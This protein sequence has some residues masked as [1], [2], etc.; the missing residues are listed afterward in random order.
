MQTTV[1]QKN[2]TRRIVGRVAVA[3]ALVVVPLAAVA[4]PALADTPSVV[5]VDRDNHNPGDRDNHNPGPGQP[6]R[7]EHRDDH[8]QPAP[9][10]GPQLPFQLPSTG[11]AG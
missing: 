9:A 6:G 7:D 1:K 11:S 8:N 3:G 5:A 2:R 4:V 10:P